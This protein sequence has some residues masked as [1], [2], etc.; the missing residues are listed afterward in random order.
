M[1]D[2]ERENWVNNDEGLYNWWQGSRLS[3]REFVR[4]NRKD[5]DKVIEKATEPPNGYKMSQWHSL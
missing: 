2:T 4:Q 5:I 3:M 1:N